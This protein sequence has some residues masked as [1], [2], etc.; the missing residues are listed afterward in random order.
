VLFA[1][2]VGVA[3][4]ANCRFSR[5]IDAHRCPPRKL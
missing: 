4:R 5:A 1:Q 2:A 3:P